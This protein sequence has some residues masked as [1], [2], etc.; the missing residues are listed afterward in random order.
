[1][2]M[3]QTVNPPRCAGWGHSELTCSCLGLG[4]MGALDAIITMLLFVCF[5]VY[6][7]MGLVFIGMGAYYAADEGAV[8]STGLYLILV[9]VLMLLVGGIAVFAN[10]KKIW[11]LLLVIELF[12][13]ALFL[14]R[15]VPALSTG[16]CHRKKL[17]CS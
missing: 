12:N 3:W 9:G 4:A 1:M 6:I 13:V 7:F 15:R 16:K 17:C 8:G 10:L 2:D 5:G 14:V 11:L